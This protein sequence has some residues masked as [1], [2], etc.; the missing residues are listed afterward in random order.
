[1]EFGADYVID[2]DK[3]D[4]IERVRELTRGR[5]ADVVVDVALSARV[6]NFS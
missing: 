3:E 2:V 1:M 4:A 6:F 5:M